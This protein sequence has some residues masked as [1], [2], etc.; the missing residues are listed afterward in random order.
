MEIWES[1]IKTGRLYTL[2]PYIEMAKYLEHR[3]RDR[4]RAIKLVER[5]LSYIDEKQELGALLGDL[6]SFDPDKVI[7]ELTHRM[8]RLQRYHSRN[9]QIE[10]DEENTD[11]D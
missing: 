1:Q 3:I 4:E 7:N 2:E 8:K 10:E 5:A 11:E 6:L 9:N